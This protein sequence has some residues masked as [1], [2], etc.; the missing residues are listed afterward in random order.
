MVGCRR[1]RNAYADDV[2]RVP[3]GRQDTLKIVIIPN[4]LRNGLEDLSPETDADAMCL[5]RPSFYYGTLP[6]DA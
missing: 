5:L 4:E 3:Y 1:R 6:H 2:C